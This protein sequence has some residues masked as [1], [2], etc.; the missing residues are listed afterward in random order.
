MIAG[1]CW[2]S[3]FPPTSEMGA[4][5]KR[6]LFVNGTMGAGKSATCAALLKQMQPAVFL[7]G[8]WCWDADPFQVTPETKRMVLDNIVY[9]LNSFLHCSA[10]ENVLF[11]WV[12]HE[13]RILDHLLQRLDTAGCA[14]KAVSLL[15]DEATLRERLGGDIRRGLRRADV[16][17]R[18]LARLPLYPRLATI[19]IE[20]SGKSVRAVAEEIA[21]L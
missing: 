8:D 14:V 13:Q 18:S 21:A 3:I 16:L 15:C 7:D 4:A 17:E 10:Y 19:K 11:C 12:M 1:R 2:Q 5:Q 20:T 6:L 9:L